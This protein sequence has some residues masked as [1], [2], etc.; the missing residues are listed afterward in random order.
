MKNLLIMSALV[1]G[2]YSLRT[3]IWDPVPDDSQGEYESTESTPVPVS[4][5]AISSADEVLAF[6]LTLEGTPYRSAGTSP[7]SGFDCSGFI[8]YV[9]QNAIDYKL[10]RDSRSMA[11]KGKKISMEEVE[12]GDLLFFTGSD[13][14]SGEIGHVGL[15]MVSEEKLFMIHTSTSRG[16]VLDEYDKISYYQERFIQARRLDI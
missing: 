13:A 5:D 11:L 1:L 10:P 16:V 2:L 4:V 12:D 15:A 6:A 3:L 14:S 7:E 8:Q 9:F